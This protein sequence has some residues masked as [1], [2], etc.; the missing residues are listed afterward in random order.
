MHILH[1]VVI[2][3]GAHQATCDRES[4]NSLHNNLLPRNRAYEMVKQKCFNGHSK[5]SFQMFF[6]GGGG[7]C[8]KQLRTLTLDIITADGSPRS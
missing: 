4:W 2:S 7:V 8:I 6:P 1:N 5:L 3:Q